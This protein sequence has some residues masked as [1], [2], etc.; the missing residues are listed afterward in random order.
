MDSSVRAPIIAVSSGFTDYGDYLGV[1]LSRPLVAAGAIPVMLPYLEDE[2]ALSRMLDH[3]DGL[4]LGF[5]RDIAPD[6]YGADPHPAMTAVSHHR[7]A[8]ELALATAALDRGLPILGICRGMQV[9]NVALGGTLHRDRSE[10]PPPAREHPGGDWKRW[11]QVCA[12]TLGRGA[13]PEHPSHPVAIAPGSRLASILGRHAIVNSYHHQAIEQLGEGLDPVA[14]APDG[15]VEA[16]ELAGPR[17]ALGVQ[18]EAQ[19]AWQA[20]GGGLGLFGA[21]VAEAGSAPAAAERS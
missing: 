10:Y 18:W 9:L 7:D 19:E 17:F 2:N 11:E 20:G 13:M 5:G 21:L 12:A 14:S 15:I 4:L 6:R 16:I 1:A 3:A 8:F